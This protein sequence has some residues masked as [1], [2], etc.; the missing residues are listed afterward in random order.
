MTNRMT[1]GNPL[2]LILTFA[3]PLL[4][5]NLFQQLYN[6]ADAAIVGQFLGSAA[7][8]SVGASSSIQ[9]L[10][11]GFCI[12]ISCGF[13]IPVAQR[14]G[15]KDL[16]EMRS[17][18]YHSYLLTLFFA[19]FLTIT[20]VLS[21]HGIL[22]ILKTPE[23]IYEN[24][25]LYLL[26]L[27]CGIPFNLLYNLLAGILR[28]IGDSKTPFFLL[29]GSTIIN[30]GLDLLFILVFRLGCA[31]A[32][33]ATITSQGLSG[34]FC[35]IL[36]IKK[37]PILKLSK[38]DRM[39]QNRK[40][41]TLTTMGVPMGL[42]YSIT[43]IGSMVMQSANNGL[44]S[45]YVS[46]FTA[47]MRIKQFAMC[48]FDALATAVSTF[49]SQNYGAG[50]FDRIKQGIKQGIAIG[51][52]YGLAIGIVLILFGRTLSMLF[53]PASDVSVLDA[54]GKYLR[55]LGMF[56]WSLGILNV[57][58][59][60]VQGLGFSGRTILSGTMEMIAR[61]IVSVF[62]VPV[63]GFSAICYADQTAWLSGTLYI[64]PVCIYVVRKLRLQSEQGKDILR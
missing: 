39:F 17:Y 15:A 27:F 4:G 64:I 37:F 35:L 44:G 48:P 54:S 59:M 32:A 51:V 55:C 31:G 41:I 20:C 6:I 29:V 12:G 57:C 21:C 63:F 18:I 10:V 28:A 26:I 30:I 13:A 19:V 50:R 45:V 47:G 36:I 33:I 58:R 14:F 2:K 8:A 56:Y 49:V 42:Q 43:A 16:K 40:I 52:S 9:F 5:G 11:L 38:E 22:H 23:N 46:G 53:I 61:I 25:Y 60:C 3:L 24:A 34:I 7:L 62:F 1:E